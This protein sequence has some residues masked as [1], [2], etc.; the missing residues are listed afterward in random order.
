M[1]WSSLFA[2]W[3]WN[4]AGNSIPRLPFSGDLYSWGV[5]HNRAHQGVD[6]VGPGAVVCHGN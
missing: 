5:K 1:A 2:T 3:V 4:K 6:G